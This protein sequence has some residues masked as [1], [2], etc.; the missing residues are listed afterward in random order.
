MNGVCVAEAA[1]KY[2]PED[3]RPREK[4]FRDGADTL[5]NSELLAI[6]LGNGTRGH[7]A[8]DIAKR[9][10][11]TVGDFSHISDMAFDYRDLKGL[12]KAKIAKLKAAVEIGRRLREEQAR[13]DKPKVTCAA[14]VANI[15]IPRMKGLRKEIFKVVV[16]DSGNRLIDIV[17]TV[18]GTVNQAYPIVREIFQRAL[19]DCAA[20]IICVHN[21]PGGTI[22][23]SFED[24]QFTQ[25]MVKAGKAL[26]IP[27][28]D[29]I[30]IA[31]DSYFSFADSHL[32][33]G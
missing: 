9:L 17:D 30:I 32:L 13:C 4:L 24:K 26:Q 15:F 29:H 8:L 7:S 11:Q 20:A 2:W 22:T 14:D 18:K 12:G 27:V 19:I 28:L 1:M 23:P 3:E 21:H 16:L 5:T 31:E 25:D 10:M 33:E 6:I